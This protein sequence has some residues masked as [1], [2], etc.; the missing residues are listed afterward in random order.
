MKPGKGIQ[1]FGVRPGSGEGDREG[2]NKKG[3]GDRGV[4]LKNGER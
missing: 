3:K 2:V 4:I 1:G